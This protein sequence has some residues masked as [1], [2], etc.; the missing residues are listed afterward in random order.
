M[1]LAPAMA[2]RH[3]RP[4]PAAATARP[5]V[6]AILAGMTGI[7]AYVRTPRM[8]IIAANEPCQGVVWGCA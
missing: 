8:E 2:R 4:K 7:P 5:A 6:M 3:R 1:R